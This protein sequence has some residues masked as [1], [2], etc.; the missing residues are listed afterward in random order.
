MHQMLAVQVRVQLQVQVL[1]LEGEVAA[2][3]MA[4]AQEWAQGSSLAVAREEQLAL[5]LVSSC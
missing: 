2:A 4:A 3:Q 1:A 5:E